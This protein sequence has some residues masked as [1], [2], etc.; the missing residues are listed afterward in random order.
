LPSPFFRWVIRLSG[1][2]RRIPSAA[3]AMNSAA[4]PRKPD[5]KPGQRWLSEKVDDFRYPD[6]GEKGKSEDQE[7]VDEETIPE[8]PADKTDAIVENDQFR[9]S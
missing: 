4:S 2:L 5:G 7:P 3:S 6:I 1:R 8:F 9:N